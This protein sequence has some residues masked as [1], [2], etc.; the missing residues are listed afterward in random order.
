MD[1]PIILSVLVTMLLYITFQQMILKSLK[2]DDDDCMQV[3]KAA[4]SMCVEYEI[5]DL[6]WAKVGTYPWWPCMVSSDPQLKVHT[7][8]N[9]R[10]NDNPDTPRTNLHVLKFTLLA[11]HS[12]S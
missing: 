8:I 11:S 12:V 2:M 10:G 6:V 7:R 5:G 3:D 4:P 1:V 9:T